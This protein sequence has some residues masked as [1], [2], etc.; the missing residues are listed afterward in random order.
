MHLLL[1]SKGAA[2]C[3]RLLL[4]PWP[5]QLLCQNLCCFAMMPLLLYAAD[6]CREGMWGY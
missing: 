2:G 6:R 4:L 3:G 5:V 1:V